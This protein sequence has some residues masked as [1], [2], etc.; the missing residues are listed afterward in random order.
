ME[1]RERNFLGVRLQRNFDSLIQMSEAIIQTKGLLVFNDNILD[2]LSFTSQE[3]RINVEYLNY[4]SLSTRSS[5]N[6]ATLEPPSTG[7]S[8]YISSFSKS[9]FHVGSRSLIL[10]AMVAA[11]RGSPNPRS[12]VRFSARVR[13]T[14]ACA[15]ILC[16]FSGEYFLIRSS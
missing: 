14:L 11:F 9:I 5:G 12:G 3:L 1:W 15:Y 8:E 16:W 10:L 4:L 2:F 7:G 6:S 13:I